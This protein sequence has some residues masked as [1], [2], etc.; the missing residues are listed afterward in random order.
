MTIINRIKTFILNLNIF[1]EL[2]TRCTLEDEIKKL[3]ER[4]KIS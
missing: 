4:N 1:S 2:D 3:N